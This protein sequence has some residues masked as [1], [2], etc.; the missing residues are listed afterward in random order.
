M[1]DLAD[2]YDDYY[3]ERLWE[4]L[5]LMYRALD[6]DDFG[7]AG[8]LRELLNRIGKQAAVA[9]RS[10]DGLWADQFIETCD[11]WVIAYLA[12]LV[13]TRLV[14]GLDARGQRLDVANTIRWR[15]RKGT[16]TTVDAVARN[17]T[18]WDVHVLEAFR[19][20]ARTRHNL[21][22]PVGTGRV[23]DGLR[24][25]GGLPVGEGLIEPMTRTPAGGLADL[26]SA[27]GARL[28]D[29][30][31]GQAFHHADLR[32]G[33]GATGWYGIEKLL[34][35]CWRLMSLE[36]TGATPVPVSGRAGEYVFD[37]TGRE[38]PL[39]LPPLQDITEITGTTG[40]W[41][42]QGPLSA[43][44]AGIMAAYGVPAAYQVT[45]GTAEEVRPETGRFR[46]GAPTGEAVTVSYHYGL[47]GPIGAGTADLTGGTALHVTAEIRVA[48]GIGL[49]ATLR[50]AHAGDTVTIADSRTYTA[51]N[52][53]A[54]I[55]A[56]SPARPSASAGTPLTIR[57]R[58]GC[59]PVIRLAEHAGPWVFTGGEGAQLELDGLFVS[60]G[61]IVLRGSFDHVK[62]VG[63]TFDPGTLATAP[64]GHGR[65]APPAG[66]RRALRAGRDVPAVLGQSVDGRAL[67]PT[68]VWI[69]ASPG[70]AAGPPDVVRC[71]EVDR[72][73]L[74][75]IRT[76]SGGLAEHVVLTDSIVQGFRTTAGPGF[77]A[78]DVFDPVLLYE[79]LSPGR[80]TPDNPR[81]PANSLSAFIWRSIG[82]HIPGAV[83][84]QLLARQPEPGD[85]VLADAL[86]LLLDR[87][88]Y[89]LERFEGVIL[90]PQ[91]DR[92]LGRDGTKRGWRDRLLLE[93]AYPLALAPAAC[94][95]A[96]ATVHMN[97]VT[98]LGRLIAHRLHATDSILDGF[99]VAD[100]TED[101]C[102][103]YSAALTRSRL[104]PLFNSARL[105]DGAALFTSRDF[106]RPG[107][108]QLL[109]TA[110]RAIISPAPGMTLLASSS[111]GTQMGA[112]AA[113]IVPIKAHALRVKYGE[114]L[115]LGLVPVIVHVT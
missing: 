54:V 29:S 41:Q 51:A 114:Y 60:G 25:G 62:I 59:R 19:G 87:D 14:T 105:S 15:R 16:V 5:P 95:V 68:R 9:R 98:V 81:A 61:E 52:D 53:V 21:D 90:S 46:L 37:P 106:G 50:D 18:G 92:L 77:T 70:R 35:Y 39:F 115:P 47:G 45:G 64:A 109:D 1:S 113:Q 17:I 26:R 69:E 84:R 102:V 20:L 99:A 66:R 107:Y 88:I 97:R 91:T 28:A 22:P 12:D 31:F 10:I 44:L 73:I 65:P 93:D 23:P 63:C 40:P 112:F 2:G 71:L 100:D 32:R 4:S 36:V 49:D 27:P 103:R 24:S 82:S 13:A 94:A 43:A 78:A 101:G 3:S 56:G 58:P 30:P 79:Q 89:R 83:R 55:P 96:D 48:G 72:S 108:A 67:A 7:A 33:T 76:R 8:P 11:D 6:S 75:P 110:D 38:I 42:V 104:P 111:S 80:N 86:N 74:G 85:D 34:V 57:A